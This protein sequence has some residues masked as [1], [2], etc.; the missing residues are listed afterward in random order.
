MATIIISDKNKDYDSFITESV[1]VLRKYEV[2]GIAISA[3]M[4]NGEVL[5]GYH[6]MELQDKILAKE[7]INLDILDQAMCVNCKN[8]EIDYE[9]EE[10]DDEENE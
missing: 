3:I 10:F 1:E 6:N 8:Y 5:T 7:Y 9:D 4:K 2:K